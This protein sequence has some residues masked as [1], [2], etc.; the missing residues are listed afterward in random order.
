[1]PGF[2]LELTYGLIYLGIDLGLVERTRQVADVGEQAVE[3]IGVGLGARIALDRGAGLFAKLLVAVR[4]AMSSK[5]SGS[6][7][8]WARL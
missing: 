4:G 2:L 1:L 6:A 8:S 5:R 7:P 3:D